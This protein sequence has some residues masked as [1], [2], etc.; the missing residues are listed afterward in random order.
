MNTTEQFMLV[1][2]RFRGQW[3]EQLKRSSQMD[4]N[5][6]RLTNMVEN[7]SVETTRLLVDSDRAPNPNKSL[8][9]LADSYDALLPRPTVRWSV[10]Y[11]LQKLLGAGGQGVV[12]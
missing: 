6:S 1:A 12:E 7:D 2:S 4:E 11:R 8:N 10:E 3:M 9:E 5:S